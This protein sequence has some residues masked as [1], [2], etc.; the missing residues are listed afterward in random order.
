VK[1]VY[2]AVLRRYPELSHSQSATMRSFLRSRAGEEFREAARRNPPKKKGASFKHRTHANWSRVQGGPRIDGVIYVKDGE[3]GRAEVQSYPKTSR[4]KKA[5]YKW[6]WEFGNRRAS[7]RATS[8]ANAKQEA[9]KRLFPRGPRKNAGHARKN[10]LHLV[11][12]E[13]VWAAPDGK[14]LILRAKRWANGYVSVTLVGLDGRELPTNHSRTKDANKAL[15]EA[16]ASLRKNAGR[17]RKNPVEMSDAAV[18]KHIIKHLHKYAE[19]IQEITPTAG[20]TRN[21][22]VRDLDQLHAEIGDARAV[23]RSCYHRLTGKRDYY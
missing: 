5:Y 3:Y 19:Y 9:D 10:P 20:G 23:A 15:K 4:R 14:E 22:K 12:K 2:T 17:A 21:L 7:G 18:L 16:A 6:R 1:K 13:E 8:W 11:T